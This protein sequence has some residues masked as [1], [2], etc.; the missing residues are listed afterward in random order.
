MYGRFA[1]GGGCPLE[2]AVGKTDADALFEQISP[3][4][5]HL[6]ALANGIGGY[7]GRLNLRLCLH[8]VCG[9]HIP[10]G[11]IIQHARAFDAAA[12][13]LNVG[14]LRFVLI[15][16]ADKRRVAENKI[17]LRPVN[18]QGVTADDFG[19]VVQRYAGAGVAEAGGGT[20][21]ALVVGEPHGHF[22]DLGGVFVD[23]DTVE[24]ADMAALHSGNI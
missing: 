11:N 8:D 3:Q 18:A 15:G 23:F 16:G 22:G 5:F 17:R 7:K 1:C 21:V 13:G 10:V 2:G 12:N 24:L 4:G 20:L 14:F 6:L 19:A 9:F